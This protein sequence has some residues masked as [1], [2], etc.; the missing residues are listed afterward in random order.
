MSNKDNDI[1]VNLISMKLKEL[2]AE[3]ANLKKKT[4][5]LGYDLFLEC[6]QDLK[7]I[8]NNYGM[9][10]DYSDLDS[11]IYLRNVETQDLFTFLER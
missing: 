4:E 5:E 8:L 6:A 11:A 7:N 2:N 9:E 1:N 10:L 3:I